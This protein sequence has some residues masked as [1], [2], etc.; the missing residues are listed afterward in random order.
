M[1]NHPRDSHPLI[2]Y[3]LDSGFS[4]QSENGETIEVDAI[5]RAVAREG[6]YHQT[7][8]I[9]VVGASGDLAKKKTYPSLL[10]LFED[11]L[12]P[13]FTVIWGYARSVKTHQQLRDHLFPHLIKTGASEIVVKDFLEKCFYHS[14]K[15]YGDE[16]AYADML[17]SISEF[18]SQ[19][20]SAACNRLFYLA[21]PPNVFGESAVAIQKVGMATTGWTR[22]IIEKPFGRDLDTCDELLSTLAAALDEDQMYRIDHYLGK[23]IVQNLLLFRFGN[24]C[25]EHMW[26]RNAIESVTLT[27]KE[28][29]GTE[30]R[31]GYFDN[32]G[33]IRDILQNHLLQ[34]LSVVAMEPP[35]GDDGDSIRNAKVAVL[36]NMDPISLDDVMLGQYDGYSDDPTIENKET[37][38]PTYAAIRCWIHTPRWEGVPF[39]MQAGKALDEK[40]CEVRVRFKPPTTLKSIGANATKLS[41]NELVF[42]LQPNPSLE[43]HNNI[44]TPGLSSNPMTSVMKMNYEEMPDLSNPDAYTRLLLDVLRGKQGSFVRDDELRRSWELFTPLLHSIERDNVRPKPY[45]YGS[46]GPADRQKWFEEMG[47]FKDPLGNGSSSANHVIRASL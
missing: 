42:R 41:S 22:V 20:P 4:F 18:E 47:K 2:R 38:C 6:W 44:K 31:G 28:P 1:N 21:I 14:G 7:L 29:F 3:R 5:H 11:N 27:F 16:E 8:S 33:I 24:S 36:E 32:F 23:E 37:N 46:K 43:L 30:G 17:S 45:I 35:V 13:E 12:L 15:S 26:N 9:V 40:L 39:L 25:W 19:S 10:N 34:V